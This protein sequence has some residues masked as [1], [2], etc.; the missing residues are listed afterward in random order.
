M[1]MQS[2]RKPVGGGTAYS[3]MS[4]LGPAGL[5]QPTD[6]SSHMPSAGVGG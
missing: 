2:L 6:H 1:S 4:F 5:A 3:N